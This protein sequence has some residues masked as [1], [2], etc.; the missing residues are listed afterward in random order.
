M[1]EAYQGRGIE[2]FVP[3]SFMVEYWGE[4]FFTSLTLASLDVAASNL[5][6]VVLPWTVGGE[7]GEKRSLTSTRGVCVH[8]VEMG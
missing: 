5:G 8:S 2:A 3:L 4:S 1:K 7:S 6:F